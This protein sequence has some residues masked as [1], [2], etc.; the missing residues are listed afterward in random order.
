MTVTDDTPSDQS[1]SDTASAADSESKAE[2][3]APTAPA[4]ETAGADAFYDALERLDTPVVT[5]A[6]YAR[7]REV[8]QAAALDELEAVTAAG[9]A[10]RCS[11]PGPAV[12]YPVEWGQLVD[13]ERLVV[14]PDRRE[15][16]ADQPAQFT[17]AQLSQFAR[18][19]TTSGDGAARYKVRSQDIWQSPHDSLEELLRTVRQTLPGRYPSVEE[20]IEGQYSRANQ[21]RLYTHDDDYTVLAA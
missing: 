13:R 1:Q 20:W 11:V 14:F 17:R 8:D 16:I 10:E 2:S 21:F 12:W 7:V 3:K 6:Q 4:D 15:I 5:A 18:L 19:T 9:D